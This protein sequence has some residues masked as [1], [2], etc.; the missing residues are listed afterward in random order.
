MKF[1]D[2]FNLTENKLEEDFKEGDKIIYHNPETDKTHE[3]IVSNVN[4]MKKKGV[5][6]TK[7]R[8]GLSPSTYSHINVPTHH[9]K[10]I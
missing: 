7:I 1:K 8:I 9:L 6:H 10:K 4:T 2:T 3:G 5:P